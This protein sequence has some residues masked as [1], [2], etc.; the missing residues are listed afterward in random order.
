MHYI[1]KI[2]FIAAA[3]CCVTLAAAG[4]AKVKERGG[5]LLAAE[6]FAANMPQHKN[7]RPVAPGESLVEAVKK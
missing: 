7:L 6:G 4:P 5:K 3:F 1:R 2:L